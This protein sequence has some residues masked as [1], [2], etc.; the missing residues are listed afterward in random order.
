VRYSTTASSG[1]A[2]SFLIQ[3]R[4]RNMI[5]SLIDDSMCLKAGKELPVNMRR[6]SNLQEPLVKR[7]SSAKAA[8]LLRQNST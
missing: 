2:A 6:G 3:P 4:K 8:I 7:V 1:D 5:M